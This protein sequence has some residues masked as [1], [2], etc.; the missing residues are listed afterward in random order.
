MLKLKLSKAFQSNIYF[1]SIILE[2]KNLV[3]TFS[4][5]LKNCQSQ[6][7]WPKFCCSFENSNETSL[8][9]CFS[10][11]SAAFS[12]SNDWQ[13]EVSFNLLLLAKITKLLTTFEKFDRSISCTYCLKIGIKNKIDND[14]IF[15]GCQP[16]DNERSDSDE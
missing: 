7:S 14:E 4:V 15:Q 6:D 3:S 9:Q 5:A 16:L 11:K 10:F 12:F 8:F 2:V 1:L 13:K